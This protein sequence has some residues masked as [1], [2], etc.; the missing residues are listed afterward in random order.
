MSN[1]E[2]PVHERRGDVWDKLM[3][4]FSLGR[5]GVVSWTSPRHWK[6]KNGNIILDV[7]HFG[8]QTGINVLECIPQKVIRRQ[9]VK[10]TRPH[11]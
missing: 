5:L 3:I 8:F 11:G 1:L 2:I 10:N 9:V 6:D 7:Q 4:I